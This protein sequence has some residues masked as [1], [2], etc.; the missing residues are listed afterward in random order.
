[1]QFRELGVDGACAISLDKHEDERGFF[2]RLWCKNE[3]SEQG[4]VFDPVQANS[5]FSY[6]KGTLRG[7][8]YQMNPY[9]EAKLMRCIRGSIFDAIIDLRPES[10]TYL[11]WI[12]IELSG[13]NFEVLF[14]PEGF[15]HGYQTLEDNSE[16]LYQVS[17]RYWPDAERGIRWNDHHFGIKW[18]ITDKLTISDK[19]RGWPDYPNY[20]DLADGSNQGL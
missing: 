1:M 20:I 8:H 13:K 17:H 16:V 4:I 2:S 3:F 11:K 10:N 15:A 6:K 9:A 18:P 14:I 5:A 19:D 7:M 12:G